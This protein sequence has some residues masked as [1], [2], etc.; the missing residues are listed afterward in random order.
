MLKR[1]L[2]IDYGSGS[3][4][5]ATPGGDSEQKQPLLEEDEIMKRLRQDA[6]YRV[7]RYD[8]LQCRRGSEVTV[9]GHFISWRENLVIGQR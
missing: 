8:L 6:E 3:P 5:V 2:T 4:A 9:S 1:L 7:P